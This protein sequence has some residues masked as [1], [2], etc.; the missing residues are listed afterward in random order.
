MWLW[1]SIV[2]VFALPSKAKLTP[3]PRA[4]AARGPKTGQFFLFALKSSWQGFQ[5]PSVSALAPE[6]MC[7]KCDTAALEQTIL[8]ILKKI[9]AFLCPHCS[10]SLHF[11]L[12]IPYILHD[13]VTYHY[14]VPLVFNL[15][16]LKK[17]CLTCMIM[18]PLCCHWLVSVA[19][20]QQPFPSPIKMFHWYRQK[21]THF[22]FWTRW[23][24][25]CWSL[26]L[27]VVWLGSSCNVHPVP[28]LRQRAYMTRFTLTICIVF[29]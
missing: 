27:C 4:E 3:K 24:G 21:H 8:L 13:K 12:Y 19:L 11:F 14:Q 1:N 18:K 6:I 26:M 17:H 5:S 2:S 15:A 29:L 22:G 20:M 23:W 7:A 10:M 25:H 9:I 16:R 28:V